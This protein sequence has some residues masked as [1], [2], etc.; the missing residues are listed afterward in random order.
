MLGALLMS[1]GGDNK[2]YN[3]NLRKA[4]NDTPDSRFEEYVDSKGNLANAWRMIDTYQKGGD[5]SG[6]AMH[7]NMTPDQQAQY[8]IKKAEGGRFNKADFG[9][10][11]AAE[12]KSLL[13]GNYPGGTEVR[14]GTDAYDKYFPDGTTRYDQFTSG[15]ARESGEGTGGTGGTWGGNDNIYF[16]ML[17]PEYTSPSA[18]D[19]SAYMPR[20]GPYDTPTP[21]LSVEGGLLYQP[22]TTEYQQQ[23]VPSNLWDYQP[24]VLSLPAVS[25]SNP[26]SGFS[27][28]EVIEASREIVNPSTKSTSNF[29]ED[30]ENRGGKG[31]GDIGYGTS[32]PTGSI[33]LGD[34]LG[35]WWG[36]DDVDYGDMSGNESEYGAGSSTGLGLGVGMGD[37]GE[38]GAGHFGLGDPDMA[39]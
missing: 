7:G 38:H 12:D 15:E 37:E 14:K 30:L 17:V 25:F 6:F 21:S 35:G 8:W 18:Q 24:P 23:F 39:G 5:M 3:L 9:R 1:G 4:F 28:E 2:Q 11:H 16:P 10:F 22:W 20:V 13:E 32:S 36:D 26:I 19:W 29:Y 33:S 27:P 34:L 31:P